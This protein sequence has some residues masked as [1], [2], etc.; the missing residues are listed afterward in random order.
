MQNIK[1]E[2]YNR[3][4]IRHCIKPLWSGWIIVLIGA[5]CSAIFLLG[6]N[7]KPVVSSLF[8]YMGAIGAFTLFFILC[9]YLFGDSRF[10]YHKTLHRRLEPTL[11]YYSESS[12]QELVEAL[13]KGDEEALGRV[14]RVSTPQLVLIRYSDAPESIYYSQVL[15]QQ[16]KSLDPLTDIYVNNINDQ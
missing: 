7:M 6:N 9:F 5:V 2:I 4:E 16:G 15:R 8:M 14:K 12:L 11:C 13:E 10:P 1:Q 3:P